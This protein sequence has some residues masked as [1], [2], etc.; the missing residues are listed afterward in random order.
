MSE[1]TITLDDLSKAIA[2]LRRENLKNQ[3]VASA[4]LRL[5][6]MTGEMDAEDL[7]AFACEVEV[8]IEALHDR[9]GAF[10]GEIAYL[11]HAWRD[12]A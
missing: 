10:A 6:S 12:E 8:L 9:L 11:E 1:K 2:P 7:S 3:L 4:V 5:C